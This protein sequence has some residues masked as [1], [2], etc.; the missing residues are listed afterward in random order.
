MFKVNHLFGGNGSVPSIG[1]T[2]SLAA[3]L[4]A[5]DRAEQA[6]EAARALARGAARRE[7][8][9]IRHLFAEGRF[10]ARASAERWC[11]QAREEGKH[12][13]ALQ[14]GDCLLRAHGLDPEKQ[15]AEIR[16]RLEK[17]RPIREAETARWQAT[18]RE[19][20]FF[21]AVAAKDFDRAAKIYIELH[22]ELFRGAKAI[23]AA[24]ARAR[25]SG[26]TERPLPE[27]GS[28]AS[29]IVSAGR[30]RRGEIK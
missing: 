22:P 15:R 4:A 11:D 30:R 12:E 5:V 20:G 25:M 27:K 19:S 23:L 21:D 17:E 14:V 6:L 16:A 26:D 1:G 2:T 24:G 8:K 18:M 10:V 29:R 28:L 13:G 3:A 9:G 7:G